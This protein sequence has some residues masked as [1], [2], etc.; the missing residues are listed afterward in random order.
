M[1]ILLISFFAMLLMGIPV[2]AVMGLSSMFYFLSRGAD[3]LTIPRGGFLFP[4]GDSSLHIC[5]GNHEPL[6]N[7]QKNF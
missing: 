4:D 7:H 6:R 1:S 2:A 3:L 5:G